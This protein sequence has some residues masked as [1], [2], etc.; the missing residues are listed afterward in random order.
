MLS[1]TPKLPIV[2]TLAFFAIITLATA[3]FLTGATSAN[4]E[5]D[6]ESPFAV[7]EPADSSRAS[8]LTEES[9]L[10]IS[11]VSDTGWEDAVTRIGS[12]RTSTGE[13]FAVVE[14]G[15]KICVVST[16][17]GPGNCAPSDQ[18]AEGQM[19]TASPAPDQCN[20]V[21]V[22][23]LVADGIGEMSIDQGGLGRTGESI[24]VTSNVYT[25]T[26]PARPTTLTADDGSVSVSMP[27]D[28]YVS[29]NS[30]C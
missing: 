6:Q 27:L 15:P 22:L 8:S 23:G 4:N 29:Q 9:K 25:A 24:P 5:P 30:A 16:G 28:S 12:A 14:V 17:R 7:L 11:M 26:L 13:E 21:H 20:S 10:L 1:N 2:A 19:F 3:T 18:A